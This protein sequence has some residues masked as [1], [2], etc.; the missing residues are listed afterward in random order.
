MDNKS[1]LVA[2]HTVADTMVAEEK[3]KQLESAVVEPAPGESQAHVQKR[4]AEEHKDTD[5]SSEELDSIKAKLF[6]K[7]QKSQQQQQRTTKS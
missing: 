6:A 4:K 3:A 2:P 5:A 1:I 7:K